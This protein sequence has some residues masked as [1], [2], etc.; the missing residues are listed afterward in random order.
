MA[1]ASLGAK[2]PWIA[3]TRPRTTNQR[4]REAQKDMNAGH[5][6]AERMKSKAAAANDKGV[7]AMGGPVTSQSTNGRVAV[8]LVVRWQGPRFRGLAALLSGSAA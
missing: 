4:N 2:A 6:E 7:D 3:V 1:S 8:A 5:P